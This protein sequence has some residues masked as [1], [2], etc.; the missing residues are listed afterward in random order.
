MCLPRPN[1]FF[2]SLYSA[3]GH[4]AASCPKA[5]TPT[6][7]VARINVF[8][9]LLM[10]SYLQLQLFVRSLWR[11][12]PIA[13]RYILPGGLEGHVSRDCTSEAKAK[14]CFKC[15]KEGHLVSLVK[16]P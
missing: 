3:V 9:L 6:W 15:G 13:E 2:P 12:I 14:S 11:I 4:Q 10:F 5:G 1:L 7:Y 16:I 8:L